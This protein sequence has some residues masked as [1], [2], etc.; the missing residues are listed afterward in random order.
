MILDFLIPGIL[1]QGNPDLFFG[2]HSSQL[3]VN[4]GTIGKHFDLKVLFTKKAQ[5]LNEM[6]INRWFSP[7]NDYFSCSQLFCLPDDIPDLFSGKLIIAFNLLVNIAV[8][9]AEVANPAELNLHG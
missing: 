7:K 9:A 1:F 6:R 4:A 5:H 3:F 2:Q 8:R